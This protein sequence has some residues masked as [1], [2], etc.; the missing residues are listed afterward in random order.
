MEQRA[1]H[2]LREDEVRAISTAL[3]G[4]SRESGGWAPWVAETLVVDDSQDAARHG[5]VIA[6]IRRHDGEDASFFIARDD[7]RLYVYDINADAPVDVADV[8]AAMA[9]VRARLVRELSGTA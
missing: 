4:W 9:T 5:T 1:H 6:D 3:T 8:A 2:G 7:G